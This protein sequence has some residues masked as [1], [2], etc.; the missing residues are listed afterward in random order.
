MARTAQMRLIELM[1][2]KQ[3]ISNVIAFLGKTGNFQFQSGIDNTDNSSSGNSN[4][5]HE[6]FSKLDQARVFLGTAD[7]TDDILNVSLPTEKDEEEAKKII[8]GV[9][10]LSRISTEKNENAKRTAEAL[11][12]AKSFANLKTSY[13][14]LEHLSFLSFRIGKIDP[15]VFDE[16][17]FSVG[18]R[19]IIVKLGDDGTKILAA[20]SKK[21]RFALDRKSTRLNSSH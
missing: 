10:E 1:V 2:L 14:E 19:A 13:S 5:E 17:K 18:N 12:E 11:K 15:A 3:D 20:S 4:D 9:A 7:F 21:G 6:L 8:E 16:L